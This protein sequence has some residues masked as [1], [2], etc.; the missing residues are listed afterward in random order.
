MTEPPAR[1]WRVPPWVWMVSILI[2]FLAVAVVTSFNAGI[3]LD[4]VHPGKSYCESG[5]LIGVA[6]VWIA[7]SAWVVFAAFCTWRLSRWR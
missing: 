7:W 4:S 5:P 3:C 1:T 2:S 6:G